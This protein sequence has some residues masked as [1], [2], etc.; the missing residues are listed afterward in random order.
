MSIFPKKYLLN[1]NTGEV[2][3]TDNYHTDCMI[4][5]MKDEHK[6]FFDTLAEALSYPENDGKKHNDGCAYCLPEYHTR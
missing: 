2:H 6:Q 3:D 1:I 5:S 4:Y